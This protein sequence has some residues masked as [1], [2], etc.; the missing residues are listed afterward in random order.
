MHV[1]CEAKFFYIEEIRHGTN[2]WHRERAL[3]PSQNQYP[4][5]KKDLEFMLETQKKAGLRI[6]CAMLEN[7]EK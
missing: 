1:S 6:F 4:L 5:E 7:L 3:E 2:V